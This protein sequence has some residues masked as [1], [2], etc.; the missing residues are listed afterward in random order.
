MLY[1]PYARSTRHDISLTSVAT[2][3]TAQAFVACLITAESGVSVPGAWL[4]VYRR[5][6]EQARASLE[7][8]RFQ[9]MLQPCWN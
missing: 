4:D 6:Y 1:G 9:V 2:S 3:P 7:P 8:S 5:A